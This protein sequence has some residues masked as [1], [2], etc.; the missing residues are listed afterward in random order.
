MGS[1]HL[2]EELI[3]GDCRSRSPLLNPSKRCKNH[4][5]E[6]RWRKLK[7][8]NSEDGKYAK[9]HPRTHKSRWGRSPFYSN[10]KYGR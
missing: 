6:G 9:K 7:R 10:S 4:R 5:R 3:S 2:E 1:P 8:V